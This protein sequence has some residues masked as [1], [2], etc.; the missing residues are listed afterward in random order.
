MTDTPPSVRADP[1]VS[2]R[3]SATDRPDE[4]SQANEQAIALQRA[5]DRRKRARST[6]LFLRDIVV[7]FLAAIIISVGIKTYLIRSFYIPSGSMENTLQI[8]DRIIVNQLVPDAIGVQRGDV[9]VFRDPGGWLPNQPLPQLNP[10][11][12]AIDW[13]MTAVGLS[14][15]DLNDHLIKRVIGLPG[16]TITC[17][18]ERG[19]ME[20]NGVPLDEPYLKLPDGTTRA[21]AIDFSVIVPAGSI[22]VMGDNRN[23]SQDSRYNQETPSKGFVPLD[24]VVGRA[25]VITWPVDHWTWLDNYPS[26]FSDI[27]AAQK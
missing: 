15:S 26:T 5:S 23:N 21:S 4:S 6:R 16:D 10:V 2:E 1:P 19:Q 11:Q 24:N 17:C 20:V 3:G 14:A 18:N 12:G 7:I 25:F 27:G 8:N 13:V 22:W 9:V